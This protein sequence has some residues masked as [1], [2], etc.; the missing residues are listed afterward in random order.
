MTDLRAEI[1]RV[2][3]ALQRNTQP[4]FFISRYGA[5]LRGVEQWLPSMTHITVN[6]VERGAHHSQQHVAPRATGAHVPGAIEFVNWMLRNRDVQAIIRHRT[7]AGE[8][9]KLVFSGHDEETERLCEQLGYEVM[10]SPIALRNQLDSKLFLAEIAVREGL[11]P[12]PHAIA[13]VETWE[14]LVRVATEFNLGDHVVIQTAYGEGGDGTWFV[15]NR[16]DFERHRDSFAGKDVRIMR[17]V[18]H[19]SLAIEAVATRDG[20]IVGPLERDIIGHKEVAI[21]EGSSSGL[22]YA[23]HLLDAQRRMDIVRRVERL[24]QVLIEQGFRGLF[25]V[26]FLLDTDSPE[27]FFGEMNPRFSGCGMVSNAMTAH[28]W[29]LPLYALHLL[30]FLDHDVE[31]TPELWNATWEELPPGNEWTNIMI[32]HLEPVTHVNT[33][34]ARTGVYHVEPDGS[35]RFVRSEPHWFGL[36]GDEVF[37][38]AYHWPGRIHVH[39]D[40]IGMLFLRRPAQKEAGFTDEAKRL[41]RAVHDL[42]ETRPLSFLERA[43]RALT[44]RASNLFGRLLQRPRA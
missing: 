17:H 28:A 39:G 29:G 19:Q 20:V 35:L 44:R 36:E 14:D 4:V 11:N 38:L 2:H 21:Y 10:S 30:E 25:E 34:F 40:T 31:L 15:R 7:P 3:E 27:V 42:Y 24:G 9:P 13:R 5:H 12:V 18:N 32:R 37:Y 1:M 16:A 43:W 41:I 23:P 33:R 26:D 6:D 22:E 8:T